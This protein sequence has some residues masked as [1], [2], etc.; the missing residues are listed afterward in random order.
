ML[1][2]LSSVASAACPSSSVD[3]LLAVE[4]AEASFIALD[5]EAFRRTTDSLDVELSCLTDSLPREVIARVHR[6]E[7]LRAFVDGNQDKAVAAFASARAIQPNY[8]F[9]EAM[10]PRGHPVSQ[11]YDEQDPSDGG[12]RPLPPPADGSIQVDGRPASALPTT[13]PSVVQWHRAD[14]SIP[15]SRYLWPGGEMFDYPTAS[16]TP[17]QTAPPV[18]DRPARSSRPLAIASGV[19]LVGA[20]GLYAVAATSRSQYFDDAATADDLDALRARTNNTFYGSV[21]LGA[22]GLGLGAS[23]VVVGRW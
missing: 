7:G 9:P 14:G 20:A 11:R 1:W 3:V 4:H 13:R 5:L 8:R 21:G 2:F 16:R 23:A 6:M 12:A 19:A 17:L 15:D 10:V 18:L 22:V